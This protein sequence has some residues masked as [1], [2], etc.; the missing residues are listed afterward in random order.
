MFSRNDE[1]P[2]SPRTR[3]LLRS[4]RFRLRNQQS[5][6]RQSHEVNRLTDAAVTTQS[7]GSASRSSAPESNSSAFQNVLQIETPVRSETVVQREPCPLLIS[8]HTS[9]NTAPD[10]A[11]LRDI[12]Q[13]PVSQTVSAD[14]P[15]MANLYS[16][17]ATRISRRLPDI[18]ASFARSRSGNRSTESSMQLTCSASNSHVT[19]DAKELERCDHCLM[20][21]PRYSMGHHAYGCPRHLAATR[22]GL[23]NV[24]DSRGSAAA[25]DVDSA[26]EDVDDAAEPA[27]VSHHS[28]EHNRMEQPPEPAAQADVTLC[29]PCQYCSTT[30]ATEEERADHLMAHNL[31]DEEN[32]RAFNR[33]SAQLH[34]RPGD[35]PID[36]EAQTDSDRAHDNPASS[37]NNRNNRVTFALMTPAGSALWI[38][39]P[40]AGSERS[41]SSGLA[42]NGT[43]TLLLPLTPSTER[44][45]A[46]SPP[47]SLNEWLERIRQ[48]ETG[49]DTAETRDSSCCSDGATPPDIITTLPTYAYT[50][51]PQAT[52]EAVS[53]PVPVNSDACMVCLE[54]YLH[55]DRLRQLPCLHVF[56]VH[57]I[58]QWLQRS[59]LCPACKRS[60]VA[61]EP[62][63]SE[64]LQ[65]VTQPSPSRPSSPP[66]SQ[67]LPSQ[68]SS[69]NL[70]RRRPQGRREGRSRHRSWRFPGY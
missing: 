15:P 49:P 39:V 62:V 34:Q 29:R 69:S 13:M 55:E 31:Q 11:H 42:R 9:T 3:S 25:E 38:A 27:Q 63:A 52:A 22:S 45:A 6:T 17:F 1:S 4:Q 18:Q 26:V 30:F 56:H 43:N 66:S 65:P 64:L 61:A 40:V 47:L 14:T 46:G 7:S 57:C 23:R 21:D 24:S 19:S 58:D 32:Q 5:P 68:P 36:Q 50:E 70:P 33:F 2:R 67:Q 60:V 41:G 54:E 28:E 10:T 12:S 16:G 44:L 37:V 59:T 20:I 53:S 48:D 35:R 8:T 51:L